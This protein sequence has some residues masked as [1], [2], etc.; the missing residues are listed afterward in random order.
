MKPTKIQLKLLK[1]YAGHHAQSPTIARMV[2][3]YWNSF[4]FPVVGVAIGCWAITAGIPA[5]G[6][7][8]V[9]AWIGVFLRDVGR[10]QVFFQTWPVLHEVIDWKRVNDLVETWEKDLG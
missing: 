9:G 2:R 3:I 7:L 10:F 6:W 5:V 4:V 8:F 1:I